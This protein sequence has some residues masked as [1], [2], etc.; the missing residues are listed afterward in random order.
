V[1]HFGVAKKN[2]GYKFFPRTEF[3]SCFYYYFA[4]PHSV[5][6]SY[7]IVYS[8]A[9]LVYFTACVFPTFFIMRSQPTV[10]AQ[11]LVTVVSMSS[12]PT[13]VEKHNNVK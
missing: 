13:V 2:L 1:E 12:Q 6:S 4:S 9:S 5:S 7:L 10:V 11:P 3:F 8:V